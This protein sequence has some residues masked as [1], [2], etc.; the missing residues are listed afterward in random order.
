MDHNTFERELWRAR[1]HMQVESQRAPYWLG[2]QRGLRRR[3]HGESYG[4]QEEHELWMSKAESDDP[5]EAQK[6]EGYRAAYLP[7]EKLPE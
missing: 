5:I 7:S 6:G 4:T 1:T 3:Y 2:Y